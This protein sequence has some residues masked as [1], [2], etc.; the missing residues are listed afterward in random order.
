MQ[1]VCRLCLTDWMSKAETKAHFN[2]TV[3]AQRYRDILVAQEN[4]DR[5]DAEREA[6][7]PAE[8]KEAVEQTEQ[9]MRRVNRL[10]SQDWIDSMKL[11]LFDYIMGDGNRSPRR[12]TRIE[13]KLK[14]Y[15]YMERLSLLELAVIKGAICDGTYF[16]S[17]AV[18][19]QSQE[20]RENGDP[21][22]FFQAL[23][24]KSGCQ[25]ICPLVGEFLRPSL[26]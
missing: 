20:E 22:E 7:R 3:H 23:R 2:G 9:L 6:S 15:M 19:R 12:W 17:M 1:T 16:L 10:G 11:S 5:Q 25:V 26:Y 18:F 8:I 4:K 24:S 14:R 21:D 13:Q